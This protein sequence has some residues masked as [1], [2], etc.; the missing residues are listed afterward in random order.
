MML[1]HL[2]KTIMPVKIF[3]TAHRRECALISNAS[4]LQSKVKM[5]RVKMILSLIILT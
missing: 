2:G 1:Y 3:S 4:A 5:I